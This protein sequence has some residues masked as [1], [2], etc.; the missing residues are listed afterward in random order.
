MQLPQKNT[1]TDKHEGLVKKSRFSL[2]DVPPENFSSRL[3]GAVSAKKIDE[4]Q[5]PNY[6]AITGALMSFW[7]MV[8]AFTSIS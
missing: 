7:A 2:P 3:A 5:S 6:F 1:T 4:G 8:Q